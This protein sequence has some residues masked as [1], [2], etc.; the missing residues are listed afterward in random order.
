VVDHRG[1]LLDVETG[2]NH[3]A[4]HVTAQYQLLLQAPGEPSLDNLLQLSDADGIG[5]VSLVVAAC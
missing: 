5:L 1:S 3:A 4:S 2:S